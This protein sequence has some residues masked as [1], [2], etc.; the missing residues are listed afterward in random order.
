MKRL[1]YFLLAL[2]AVLTTSC[3]K[4]VVEKIVEV[5]VDTS[6]M[7][8]GL[9]TFMSDENLRAL[10][11][12]Q[13]AIFRNA[14]DVDMVIVSYGVNVMFQNSVWMPTLAENVINLQGFQATPVNQYTLTRWHHMSSY[15]GRK[16]GDGVNEEI[17]ILNEQFYDDN[18]YVYKVIHF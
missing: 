1:L 8:E 5:E 6:D 4:E 12:E 15:D 17:P 14:D 18:Q 11:D 2:A 3:D 13:V 7:P 16:L 9:K 10:Y